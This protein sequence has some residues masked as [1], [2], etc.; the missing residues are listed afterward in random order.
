MPR[1]L[2][3]IHGDLPALFPI[4]LLPVKPGQV[5]ADRMLWKEDQW[6]R[7][8]GRKEQGAKPFSAVEM[9]WFLHDIV[10]T[11][12]RINPTLMEPRHSRRWTRFA[13]KLLTD[14]GEEVKAPDL[15]LVDWRVSPMQEATWKDVVCCMSIEDFTQV[16]RQFEAN[17]RMVRY[18]EHMFKIQ[19]GRRFVLTFLV[20]NNEFQI[21]LFDRSGP[22]YCARRP[23]IHDNPLEVLHAILGTLHLGPQE[24]GY[25]PTLYDKEVRHI[26]GLFM[27]VGGVEYAVVP[28]YQENKMYGRGTVCFYGTS[29]ID[30][31]L[32]VIKDQWTTVSRRNRELEILEHLNEG[33]ESSVCAP[34]G[35]RV[36]PKVIAGEI[37][38]VRVL[39]FANAHYNEREGLWEGTPVFINVNDT[40]ALLRYPN[41]TGQGILA[42]WRMVTAPLAQKIQKFP[43][44]EGMA[45]TFKDIVYGI[46]ITH[47][48]G[49][50]HRDVS[51]RNVLWYDHQGSARGLLI[52]YDAANF[53][54]RDGAPTVEGTLRYMSLNRLVQHPKYPHCYSEDLESLFY[55]MCFVLSVYDGPSYKP[56][57]F[58]PGAVENLGIIKCSERK[59]GETLDKGTIYLRK[60]NAVIECKERLFDDIAPYFEVFK[61]CLRRLHKLLFEPKFYGAVP[62]SQTKNYGRTKKTLMN[63]YEQFKENN[64]DKL[65][66]VKQA[67]NDK[68]W[69]WDRPPDVLFDAF[70]EALDDTLEEIR[71]RD[72]AQANVKPLQQDIEE[73]QAQTVAPTDENLE[74]K[75]LQPEDENMTEAKSPSKRTYA[76]AK[77]KPRKIIMVNN[78][79]RK[80]TKSVPGPPFHPSVAANV[81]LDTM[82]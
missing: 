72:A 55:V 78:S 12:A 1:S 34:D 44:L 37:V 80:R 54:D 70:V 7:W 2:E 60:I 22:L 53:V 35:V 57:N 3:P 68:L 47:S 39:A 26:E 67:I 36:I 25:D 75:K 82:E 23:N 24:L 63:R 15:V 13:D 64:S 45:M 58:P 81:P 42:H 19:P 74:A 65:D 14:G 50:I 46:R 66:G 71:R 49:I 61:D 4:H 43:S 52:D 79:R 69:I 18:A 27:Q 76:Q 5:F 11:A 21:N 41:Q 33:E 31:S 16:N 56:R 30:G 9:E 40:T 6:A 73:P 77:L 8:P 29:Q 59:P 20:V 62:S 32:V 10:V 51:H 17:A 28:F 38:G 48:K